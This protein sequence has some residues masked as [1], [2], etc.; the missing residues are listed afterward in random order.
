MKINIISKDREGNGGR[1]EGRNRVV[2]DSPAFHA[3]VMVIFS[4][5]CSS[6]LPADLETE[7]PWQYFPSSSRSFG[8]CSAWYFSHSLWQ[9]W[10]CL[11]LLWQQMRDERCCTGQRSVHIHR[12]TSGDIWETV[13]YQKWTRVLETYAKIVIS[14]Y[15]LPSILMRVR[16]KDR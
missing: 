8:S 2:M 1:G 4:Q 7:C 11:W 6:L 13:I 5:R 15:L 16:F 14:Y 10:L 9:C 3:P 12:V